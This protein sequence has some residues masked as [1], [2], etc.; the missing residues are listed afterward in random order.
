MAIDTTTWGVTAAAVA[1]LASHADIEPATAS[2]PD[3]ATASTRQVSTQDV[4]AWIVD[5]SAI[6]DLKTRNR[7]ALTEANQVRIAATA[8][9][10]VTNGAAAYLVD[11]AYPARA[12]IADNSSYGNVLWTRYKTG[13]QEL[14]EEVN[15]WAEQ[16]DDTAAP[17]GPLQ[18]S[19][20]FPAP[21]FTD[22]MRW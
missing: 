18:I 14:E 13:L 2:D 11:A 15:E 21:R 3:F 10:V 5:V 12:G 1:A 9:A 17:A 4:E 7:A 16:G 8:K 22:D 19:H 6:V 20:S